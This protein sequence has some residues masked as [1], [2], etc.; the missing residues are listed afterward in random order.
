MNNKP[1]NTP[2]SGQQGWQKTTPK[3]ASPAPTPAVGRGSHLLNPAENP[4]NPA[5]VT[6]DDIWATYK[7][8]IQE[9]NVLAPQVTKAD[10]EE[11]MWMRDQAERMG[12]DPDTHAGPILF[13]DDEWEMMT[14]TREARIAFGYELPCGCR[15]GSCSSEYGGDCFNYDYDTDEREIWHESICEDPKS[16]FY[17]D[18][19]GR[20]WA[21]REFPDLGM[22]EYADTGDSLQ[23]Y[24]SKGTI[25][26]TVSLIEADASMRNF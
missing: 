13:T 8:N 23:A 9:D 15:P 24:S 14:S 16:V 19:R 7:E 21:I 18:S 17:T 1:S 26:E 4:S 3:A 10:V 20:K 2:K 11:R 12:L 22:S 5:A 25:E 6:L